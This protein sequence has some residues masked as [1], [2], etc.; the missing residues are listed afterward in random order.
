MHS[1]C[2]G[3]PPPSPRLGGAVDA[4]PLLAAEGPITGVRRGHQPSVLSMDQVQAQAAS[5]RPASYLTSTPLIRPTDPRRHFFTQRPCGRQGGR[6]GAAV[7][8]GG[9]ARASA[10][11]VPSCLHLHDL[12]ALGC[13]AA[14]AAS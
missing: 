13:A 9:S 8:G 10:R 3:R 14:A 7:S 11:G 1:Q 6:S 12:S 2:T 5:C 4:P